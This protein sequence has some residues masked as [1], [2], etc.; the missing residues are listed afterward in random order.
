MAETTRTATLTIDGQSYEL[1]IYSP[2]AGPDVVDITKLYGKAGVFTHDPGFT[3]TSAC[4]SS[5]TFIDGD[6]GE[7]LAPRLHDRP[8]AGNRIYPRG[9]YL[10]LYGR[11]ATRGGA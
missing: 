5:I 3:S 8:A 2:T 4:E 11:P 7:L 9:R 6:K 10:L 1:P